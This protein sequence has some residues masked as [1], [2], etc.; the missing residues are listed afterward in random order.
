MQPALVKKNSPTTL[1][2]MKQLDRL[3]QKMDKLDEIA[4]M[5]MRL[6]R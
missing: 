1:E 4:K 3:E 2:E 5:Y 6:A